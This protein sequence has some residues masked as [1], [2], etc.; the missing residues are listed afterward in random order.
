VKHVV[1]RGELKPGHRQEAIRVLDSGGVVLL[2]CGDGYLLVSRSEERLQPFGYSLS[3]RLVR[4]RAQFDALLAAPAANVSRLADAFLPGD[5]TMVVNTGPGRTGVMMPRS[6]FAAELLSERPE[7]LFFQEVLDCDSDQ[8]LQMAHADRVD[9]WLDVGGVH[10][11][12]STLVDVT[13]D[14]P[15]VGRKGAISILDIERVLGAKVKLGPSV[16]FSALFVCT[17]NTC[18]SAMARG[19]LEQRLRNQRVV[20]YSAGT[21]TVPGLP[22]TEGARQTVLAMGIDLSRHFS[23]PLTA[24]QIRDADLVL[25]MEPKHKRR[26]IE[27]FPEAASRTFLLTEFKGSKAE[28]LKGSRE[29]IYDPMGSSLEVFREVAKIIAKCLEKVAQDIEW[30]LAPP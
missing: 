16:I 26:V 12:P 2:P 5:L 10:L 1:V 24:S 11:L 13:Q 21:N 17:G 30:R 25:G 9:L 27:L 29:E 23:T 15:L 18:R 20:I 14:P 3:Q 28:R 6:S 4:D 7:S 19:I 8:D 22:A